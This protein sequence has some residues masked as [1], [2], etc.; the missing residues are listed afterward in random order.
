MH[1]WF[2]CQTAKFGGKDAIAAVR[3]IVGS[4]NKFDFQQVSPSLPQLDLPDLQPFFLAMLHLNKRRI[5]HTDEKFSFLTPDSWRIEPAIQRE[6]EQVHFNRYLRDRNA[7]HHLLGVGHKLFDAALA[8]A[9]GF[10]E[11]VAV[12]PGLKQILFI[13]LISDR[14]TGNSNIRQAIAAVSI[15]LFNQAYILKDWELIA[16]INLYL[17]DFKKIPESSNCCTL[18]V[19]EIC[20]SLTSAEQ[21]LEKHLDNLDLPFKILAIEAIAVLLPSNKRVA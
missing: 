13:F 1:Q 15:D 6:Y 21:F 8:Q 5:K 9:M 10:S 17:A 2:D 14:V 3:E 4:C 11:C 20:Q 18:S 12:L 19:G 7:I 16:T